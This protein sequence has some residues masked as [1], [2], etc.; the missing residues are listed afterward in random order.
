MRV[1]D[2]SIVIDQD[3]TILQF[4]VDRSAHEHPEVPRD[5]RSKIARAYRAKQAKKLRFGKA[6]KNIGMLA[7]AGALLGLGGEAAQGISNRISGPLSRSRGYRAMLKEAPDLKR[8]YKET[9]LK[10]HYRT[11]FNFSPTS[12][13]DPLAAASMMRRQM[14]FKDVGYQA[15]DLQNLANIERSVS[16]RRGVFRDAFDPKSLASKSVGF[17]GPLI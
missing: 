15:Q 1:R 13:K 2:A 9:D 11:L 12:A 7:G 3:G 5:R 6:L 17:A 10:K 8:D 16:D 4:N 14:R